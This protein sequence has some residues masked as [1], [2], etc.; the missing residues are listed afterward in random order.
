MQKI[1]PCLWFDTNAEEAINHYLSIFKNGKLI[2]S[3]RY[4]D[5]MPM[6]SGTFLTGVVEIEGQEIMFLNG[7]PVYKLSPAFSL[8]IDCKDQD[9]VDYYWNRLLEGGR[10]DQCGWLTDKFGVSWQ[11]VPSVLEKLM[12]DPDPVKAAR[13]TQAMLQMVKLDIAGLQRAYNGS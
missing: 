5:A 2:S 1:T 8:V 6:P 11:V 7:G 12:S 4:G 9:E 3:S 13:V 10:P